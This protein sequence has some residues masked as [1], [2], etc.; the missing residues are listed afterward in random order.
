MIKKT[1]QK[2]RRIETKDK[3]KKA[4]RTREGDKKSNK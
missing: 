3:E 1:R 4:T 2:V